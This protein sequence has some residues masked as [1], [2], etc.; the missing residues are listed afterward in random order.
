MLAGGGGQVEY[1]FTVAGMPWCITTSQTLA[2]LIATTEVIEQMFGEPGSLQADEIVF[3]PGIREIGSISV[4][5]DESDGLRFSP[6][7]IELDDIPIDIG[8]TIANY[9]ESDASNG[10]PGVSLLL[11]PRRNTSIKWGRIYQRIDSDSS[12]MVFYNDGGLYTW[13]SDLSGTS[14]REV[15]WCDQECMIID[16]STIAATGNGDGSYTVD[17][18]TRGVLRTRS[19]THIV[20]R[21]D[22]SNM[23]V[24]NAP[25]GGVAGRVGYIWAFALGRDR[26]SCGQPSI[27]H[28]G[29][30]S[31]GISWTGTSWKLSVKGFDSI[32][33]RAYRQSQEPLRTS[34]AKFFV[35][36]YNTTYHASSMDS[37]KDATY[38]PS[39]DIA[40]SENGGTHKYIWLNTGSL[41]TKMYDTHQEVI[42]AVGAALAAAT[43]AGDL[44]YTYVVDEGGIRNISNNNPVKIYGR[45]VIPFNMGMCT[46]DVQ[47]K[48]KE[49]LSLGLT[50]WS[51]LDSAAEYP[52]WA[53][54]QDGEVRTDD[55]TAV[56]CRP[57]GGDSVSDG[58]PYLYTQYSLD[59]VARKRW[60][61]FY[62]SQAF[63]LPT[64]LSAW[65]IYLSS[66]LSTD[67]LFLDSPIYFGNKASGT[68]HDTH[69]TSTGGLSDPIAVDVVKRVYKGSIDTATVQS[70]GTVKLVMSADNGCEYP[71]F[72]SD[73]PCLVPIA[74]K[75]GSVGWGAV[76]CHAPSLLQEDPF[77][78]QHCTDIVG[79]KPS[80]IFRALLGDPDSSTTATVPKHMIA[81][82]VPD[83]FSIPSRPYSSSDC[84]DWVEL[85]ALTQP[86]VAGEKYRLVPPGD[87]SIFEILMSES[88]YRGLRPT[89]KWDAS[90]TPHRHVIGFEPIG[91]INATRA[92]RLGR[93]INE[94]D[95]LHGSEL[96]YKTDGE[97][98]FS[99]VKALA[100]Y[101]GK[102]H[103]IEVTVNDITGFGVL[104]GQHNEL[105]LPSYVSQLPGSGPGSISSGALQDIEEHFSYKILEKLNSPL[106]VLS[107]ECLDT[108]LLR[109]AVGSGCV[110][111]NDYIRNP[112]TGEYGIVSWP[113]R[114]RSITWSPHSAKFKTD[115]SSSPDIYRGFGPTMLVE[116]GGATIT[117]DTTMIIEPENYEFARSADGTDLSFFDCIIRNPAYD[118]S[119]D[120]YIPRRDCSCGD[121][122]VRVHKKNESTLT[123]GYQAVISDVDVEYGT[124]TLTIQSSD[125]ESVL[126]VEHSFDAIGSVDYASGSHSCLV[127]PGNIGVIG[128]DSQVEQ[129]DGPRTTSWTLIDTDYRAPYGVY[130]GD[131]VCSE[132]G[133]DGVYLYDGSTFTSLGTPQN[134]SGTSLWIAQVGSLIVHGAIDGYIDTH[135]GTGT[136]WTDLGRPSNHAITGIV[137][138]GGN[139]T[140]ATSQGVVWYHNGSTWVTRG[141]PT[142]IGGDLGLA[143]TE[144]GDLVAAQRYY[145]G[146]D[147][148]TSAAKWTSGTS[149]SSLGVVHSQ[150]GAYGGTDRCNIVTV[151]D[152]IYLCN[153]NG[154]SIYR[155]SD[156]ESTW[157]EIENV[158]STSYSISVL[159]TDGDF[160]YAFDTDENARRITLPQN[161]ND[162]YIEYDWSSDSNTQ[163]C[164]RNNWLYRANSDGEVEDDSGNTTPASRWS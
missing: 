108:A 24:A 61:E 27:I 47:T 36:G 162:L 10:I 65:Y 72:G 161:A 151:G 28:S 96:I 58:T 159:A 91:A 48:I 38:G 32:F 149:W 12:E 146:T 84:I 101:N 45:L 103:D 90:Q 88:L 2:S 154:R 114:C 126:S 40:V 134:T 116:A 69:R 77:I 110:V 92:W 132:D 144:S 16:P 51:T 68:I 54:C 109:L 102:E 136:T 133:G 49:S 156:A 117:G 19:Q 138:H 53:T 78:V 30:V 42:D 87:K 94:S 34:L 153:R 148:R 120:P 145:S 125:W 130:N 119:T 164:Q 129:W 13:I 63:W 15:I 155:Y 29:R 73:V 152:D 97:Q 82:S 39:P 44:S 107:L 142:G 6:V 31:Q 21:G 46:K 104:G 43:T 99:S 83:A 5:S 41:Q 106:A 22:Q 143:V 52:C 62:S 7:S 66:D 76:M 113:H 79:D 11:D 18:D 20:A 150:A 37:F 105:D 14:T 98:S 139:I 35:C 1:A 127:C 50:E 33:D 123:P 55:G 85:D 8:D 124:A 67:Q 4:R 140:V 158:A 9:D 163:P 128:S 3:A 26:T 131:L 89:W 141:A 118:G 160:V 112:Y 100:N 23:V 70:D 157:T 111:T 57:F 147:Y 137:D 75:G 115:L 60:D 56:T 121:Y 71:A 93:T 59:C 25:I 95:I 80:D 17:I 122:A 74:G 81:D 86:V 64:D 135:P